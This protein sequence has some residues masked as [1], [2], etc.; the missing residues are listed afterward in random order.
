MI[1][2]IVRTF[3][4]NVVAWAMVGTAAA[5]VA[6]W[7][8]AGVQTWRIDRLKA[9][10]A[11]DRLKAVERA[12]TA[13]RAKGAQG[14]EIGA[15]VERVRVEYRDR[16]RTITQEIPRYVTVESDRRCIVPRGF[17]SVHDAAARGEVLPEGPAA[18]AVANDAPSGVALSAVASTVVGNYAGCT[19][20]R[21][22]LVGLQAW[23]NQVVL[24]EPPGEGAR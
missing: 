5:A 23:V 11:R 4:P 3:A 8:V 16:Y 13:E 12:L 22:R 7:G 10:A 20:D 2:W 18:A 15:V 17:V 6:G 9:D 19:D 24:A 1:G 14:A 21:A